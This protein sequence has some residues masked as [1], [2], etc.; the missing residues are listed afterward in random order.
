M[1]QRKDRAVAHLQAVSDQISDT[2][3]KQQGLKSDTKDVLGGI[4][5]NAMAPPL[6]VGHKVI[7][8]FLRPTNFLFC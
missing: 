4:P 8:Q 5:V 2:L 7:R 3:R 1:N 6:E